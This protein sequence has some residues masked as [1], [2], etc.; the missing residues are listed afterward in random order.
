MSIVKQKHSTDHIAVNLEGDS[1]SESLS[2]RV[3]K[4]EKKLSAKKQGN[5]K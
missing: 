4:R 3:S 1:E 2:K 5:S